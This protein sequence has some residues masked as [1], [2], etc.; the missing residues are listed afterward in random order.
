MKLIKTLI[1]AM[2]L[3]VLIAAVL[4]IDGPH[5][6]AWTVVSFAAGVFLTLV[7]KCKKSEY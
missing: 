6:V 3:A 7:W 1:T 5:Y 2:V 4:L